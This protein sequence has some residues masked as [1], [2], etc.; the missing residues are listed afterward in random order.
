MSSLI[1]SS[2]SRSSPSIFIYHS[3]SHPC[4]LSIYFHLFP[5]QSSS[6]SLQSHSLLFISI[7]ILSFHSISSSQTYAIP[8]LTLHSHT[9]CGIVAFHYP[10]LSFISS[11]PLLIPLFSILYIPLFSFFS[12]ASSFINYEFYTLFVRILVNACSFVVLIRN[13]LSQLDI[14]AIASDG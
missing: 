12:F 13:T 1:I 7:P 2:A 11:I 3:Y 4:S 5:S 10:M 6:Q 14:V 9:F 8:L